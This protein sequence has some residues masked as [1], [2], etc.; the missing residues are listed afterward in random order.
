MHL[1]ISLL[2]A[3]TTYRSIG[4]IVVNA[5]WA[6]SGLA[7]WCN[8]GTY[9]PALG[10]WLHSKSSACYSTFGPTS[11]KTVD[12]W[13]AP[14]SYVVGGQTGYCSIPG[15]I[16]PG[17][18]GPYVGYLYTSYYTICGGQAAVVSQNLTDGNGNVY[19]KYYGE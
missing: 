4:A 5:P 12:N 14:G 19:G 7:Q 15:P 1:A 6:Q 3:L 16:V 11:C 13:W 17:I 2:L 18:T 10:D 8:A 9:S